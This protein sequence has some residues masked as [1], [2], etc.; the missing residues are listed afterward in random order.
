VY[1]HY[2]RPPLFPDAVS[3][4][5]F[6][7]KDDLTPCGRKCDDCFH[8]KS[9][10]CVCCP[11]VT[12]YKDPFNTGL[13]IVVSPALIHIEEVARPPDCTVRLS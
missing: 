9:D 4:Q 12:E 8:Y 3:L 13:A 6:P 11:A 10:Q 7:E 5:V 2:S 1:V